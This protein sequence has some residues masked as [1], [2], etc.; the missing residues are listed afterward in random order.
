ME[1]YLTGW[2]KLSGWFY[3]EYEFMCIYSSAMPLT[4]KSKDELHRPNQQPM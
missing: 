3:N 4:D 2:Q 1:Q